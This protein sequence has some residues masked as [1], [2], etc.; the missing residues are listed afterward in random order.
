MYSIKNLKT[1]AFILLIIFGTCQCQ[2]KMADEENPKKTDPEF[3]TQQKP[4][5]KEDGIIYFSLDTGRNWINASKGLPQ[6][7]SIGLGGISTSSDLLGVATKEN[8]IYLFDFEESD[9]ISIP[10]DQEML[11]SN[12]GAMILYNNDIYTGTQYG[13]VFFSNNKG[14]SWQTKNNGLGNLTIRRFAEID[15]KL[16]VGTNDGLY[17]YNVLLNEWNLE[18]GQNSLQV[19][20][21]TE[22]DGTIY[23]A[24]NQGAFKFEMQ[25]NN[26]R[27]VIYDSSLHNISAVDKTIYAMT[28]NEL[29]SSDDKGETWQSDQKGLPRELYT[30]DV[31]EHANTLFA[32][33]WDG[34]YSKTNSDLDWKL[35]STGVPPKFAASNLT[36]CNG[37]LVIT[38]S[39][40]KLR[41]G[42]TTER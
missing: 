32:G 24:T 40:R 18:Y 38:T 31:I 37:I 1:S 27:K 16:Y 26:W 33:Q 34:V 30:F 22:F 12:I 7:V 19:N 5:E 42:L 3:T 41:S 36:A 11:N 10:T 23:I 39:E 9:W 25:T 17:S 6:K 13:G 4:A 14:K 8:G 28:Y 35:S 20:G 21:I 29:F 2:N 15:G